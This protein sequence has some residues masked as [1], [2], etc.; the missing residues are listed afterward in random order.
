VIDQ[1]LDLLGPFSGVSADLPRLSPRPWTAEDSYSIQFR[2]AGGA[3]GVL[4]GTVAAWGPMVML[5]RIAG[6]KGTL[7]MEGD[8]VRVSDGD[9]ERRLDVPGDLALP[10]GEPP[11]ADLLTTTYDQL[12]SFGLEVQPFTR[13][14]EVFAA[15]IAGEP[16]PDDPRPAT[17]ADG[18]ATMDVLDAVRRADHDGGWVEVPPPEPR[19]ADDGA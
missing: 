2:T 7:W 15:R 6:S 1:M 10:P 4:Q 13:L 18:V 9:G 17:F 19:E 14:Y 12:H 11:A 5:T 16:G 3:S 8:E